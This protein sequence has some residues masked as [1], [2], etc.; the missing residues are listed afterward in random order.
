MEYQEAIDY[1]YNSLPVFQ[2]IGAAAYKPGLGTSLALDN[3]FGN[4]HRRYPSI[5][6]AGTNGKG[7][8]AHT[9]AAVLQSAGY[10]TGLYTSPHLFDFR[11]RI[12][13]NGEMITREAV[14]SFVERWLELHS[15]EE[16]AGLTPSFFELTST[17][18]FEYFAECGVDVAVIETGLGGRLDSTNIIT[19]V[20]SVITNISLDHTSLL[21]DTLEKIAYEKAGII[22]SGVLVVIG[23]WQRD[24]TPVFE[25]KAEE[26]GAQLVY[27]PPVSGEHTGDHILYTATEYG[28]ISGELAGDYQIKNTATVLAAVRELRKMSFE[29]GD[30]AV[31]T[32]FA[33]V[34]GLTGLMGR[35][36]KIGENPLTVC[37]TGHNAGGWEYIVRQLDKRT[38]GTVHLIIGFAAD[39]EISIVLDMI[40]RLEV[41]VK[42]YFAAPSV[43]RGL[44]AE[45]LAAAAAEH[46]LAGIATPDVNQALEVARQNADPSDDMIFIGGSNFLI[47]DLKLM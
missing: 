18:A 5:H 21:G 19:P 2:R 7:S 44:E 6:V 30:E 46:G 24:T 31:R 3:M 9:L 13:V 29:I 26:C 36:M 42:L 38:S 34:T 39:K 14:V 1:L 40:K 33:N 22:K 15:L 16:N 11:E 12:R 17:M 41:P 8:T 32:G 45:K 25:K 47:A 28:E 43:K 27:A 37:D 10:R 35:W 4:P 23:E 20:L